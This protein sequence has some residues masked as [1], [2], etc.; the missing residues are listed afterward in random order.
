METAV[1][2]LYAMVAGSALVT[3]WL[4]HQIV[5]IIK[6]LKERIETLE[7]RVGWPLEPQKREWTSTLGDWMDDE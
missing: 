3:A 7:S 2:V 5:A 6:L 1:F 4:V